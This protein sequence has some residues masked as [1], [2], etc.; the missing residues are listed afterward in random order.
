MDA[1]ALQ[2]QQAPG[3]PV[4]ALASLRLPH[5][6]PLQQPQLVQHS[7]AWSQPTSISV[8]QHSAAQA[9]TH[10]LLS[11]QPFVPLQPLGLAALLPPQFLFEQSLGYDAPFAHLLGSTYPQGPSAQQYQPHLTHAM[12]PS[13][14]AASAMYGRWARQQH[15]GVAPAPPAGPLA[16]A[17]PCRLMP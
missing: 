5:P 13:P 12:G 17:A 2:Q 9:L 8:A 11:S 3:G 1:A 16:A 6:Q 7:D 10:H 4:Q 14:A 15:S